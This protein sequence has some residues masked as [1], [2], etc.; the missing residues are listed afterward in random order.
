M[1]SIL[2]SAD[3]DWKWLHP[4]D[5]VD[6]AK[7][8]PDFH[9]TFFTAEFDDHAWKNGTDS[10]KEGGGFGYGDAWFTGVDIGLPGVADDNG[11][12]NGKSAYF[13]HRFSTTKNRA[14]L[15]LR[16]QFDDGMI[17]YL[18]G[19][20][21]AR[22][23]MSEGAEGY[24]LPAASAMGGD[25]ERT[26]FRIPLVDATLE[27]GEHLLAISLHNPAEP[28]SDLRIGG[29]SLVEVATVAIEGEQEITARTK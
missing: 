17:I 26:T 13:R 5:G 19:E 23:N 6:P 9:Q 14:N 20:E 3:G 18:D 4:T 15:E 25:G 27:P 12:R 2:V 22:V 1:R 29:I 7:G 28:S 10:E 21:V 11:K 16:C 8:D 24:K